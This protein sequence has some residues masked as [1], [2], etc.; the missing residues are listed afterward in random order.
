MRL[1]VP[2]HL[3]LFVIL[4]FPVNS[5]ADGFQKFTKEVSFLKL[6]LECSEEKR[7]PPMMGF[8]ALYICTLGE[9]KTVKLYVSEKPDSGKVQ[10][11]G[12]IWNDYKVNTGY[13]IH[14]GL[15][16][17]EKALEF[18][19]DMYVPARKDEILKTFWDSKSVDFSTSDFSIYFTH[20]TG[21]QKDERLI[22]IEEK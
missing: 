4:L 1:S 22:L 6:M 19:I 15:K 9:T 16:E 5:S 2:S 18:L 7:V 14:S 17:A 11:I 13:G 12:M 3:C 10:N 21:L 8:G 20:K